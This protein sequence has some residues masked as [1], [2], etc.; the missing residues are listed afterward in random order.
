[1]GHPTRLGRDPRVLDSS[2]GHALF[3][4]PKP[5]AAAA[6]APR[7]PGPPTPP[8]N[9]RA[10]AAHTQRARGGGG[11]QA[12]AAAAAR[13]GSDWDVA[14]IVLGFDPNP[15]CRRRKVNRLL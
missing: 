5:D 1:M 12:G 8:K 11:D 4:L 14:V 13:I 10:R 7:L 9:G 15:S 2:L 3:F 6:P